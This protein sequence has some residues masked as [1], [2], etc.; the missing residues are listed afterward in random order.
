MLLPF[1]NQSS[2]HIDIHIRIGQS[3]AA[4]ATS[5]AVSRDELYANRRRTINASCCRSSIAKTEN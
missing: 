1:D 2:H 3:P 4:T 5:A